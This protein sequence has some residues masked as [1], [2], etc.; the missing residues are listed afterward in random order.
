MRH[1]LFAWL[2]FQ[3][4]KSNVFPRLTSSSNVT[5]SKYRLTTSYRPRQKSSVRHSA[6]RAHSIVFQAGYRRQ[7]TLRDAQD[8]PHRIFRRVAGKL[9][10]ALCAARGRDKTRAGQ[11]NHDLF[12]IFRRNF[13][14]FRDIAQRDVTCCVMLRKID[15]QTKCIS[16]LSRNLHKHTPFASLCHKIA[17]IS[18][19]TA[20][21]QRFCRDRITSSI[22]WL[23]CSTSHFSSVAERR[24]AP[25]PRMIIC[26]MPSD[27]ATR[28][29]CLRDRS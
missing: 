10:S 2:C 17:P 7:R 9:V 26:S 19:I 18:S 8:L 16:S 3:M 23:A 25:C 13:L 20:R 29:R 11:L 28:T 22:C 21:D 6:A 4:E 12:Q 1:A 5:E 15:H 14:T 27:V 24:C